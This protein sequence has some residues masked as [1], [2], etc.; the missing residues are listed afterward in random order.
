MLGSLANR[1]CNIPSHITASRGAVVHPIGFLLFLCLFFSP[2]SVNADY[3]FIPHISA[4]VRYTDNVFLDPVDEEYD[5]ITFVTPGVDLGVA[6]Q[7]AALNIAYSPS[8]RAY[9]RF[10]ENNYWRQD[11][12][13]NGWAEISKNTRLELTNAFL[14]TEDPYSETDPTVR[15]GREPY[16]QNTTAVTMANRFGAND[17]FTLGYTYYVL[18]NDDPTVEDSS[19]HQPNFLAT[20]WFSPNRYAFELAGKFTVSE[21]D[22][23]EDFEDL[24]ARIRFIKRF[25][26]H[27]DGYVEYSHVYLDYFGEREGYKVYSPTVGFAWD[28]RE[29]TRFA[30]SFGYFYRDNE[31]SKDDDGIAGSIETIYNW[32]KNSSIAINGEVGYDRTYFGSE[33]L[34]F[35]PFYRVGGTLSHQLSQRCTGGV[36]VGYRRSLY[37]DENPD[38]EDRIWRAGFGLAFQALPWMTFSLDYLYH[39]LNSNVDVN[40]YSE[41]RG[42][43]TVTLT[44]RQRVGS[45]RES[46][47]VRQPS[48][49][50]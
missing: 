13:L 14:Y 9:T 1:I 23:S 45:G 37:I 22:V 5:V 27:L 44:P 19:Y 31:V 26:R 10:P 8:Y 20:Y 43:L 41:N 25:G 30:A 28:E 7:Y 15:R 11:V 50:F 35:T 36:F 6:G 12:A 39:T 17:V 42:T 40:D 48:G 33:N 16:S 34:G 3:R 47:E 32:R 21:F 2:N 46:S 29:N 49:R 18:N 38:R 4:G 24:D